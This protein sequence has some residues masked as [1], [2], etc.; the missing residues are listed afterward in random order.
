[1]DR[2]GI[3]KNTAGPPKQVE[4]IIAVEDK[5]FVE[6]IKAPSDYFSPNRYR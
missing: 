4:K 1:M 3:E 5:S 2:L 6:Q